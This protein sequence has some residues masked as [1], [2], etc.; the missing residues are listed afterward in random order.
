MF[1][2]GQWAQNNKKALRRLDKAGFEI[3]NHSWDHKDLTDLSDIRDPKPTAQGAEGHLGCHRQP[4]PVH[5]TT[6]G[7][8]ELAREEHLG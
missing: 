1:V 8:D 4:G 7:R 6:H 3:A 5:A 2:L